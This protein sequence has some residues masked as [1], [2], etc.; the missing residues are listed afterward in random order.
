M[1]WH[2]FVILDKHVQ[3]TYTVYIHVSDT[4]KTYVCALEHEY[5]HVIVLMKS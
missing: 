2:K 4:Y 3:Y 5:A 1:F